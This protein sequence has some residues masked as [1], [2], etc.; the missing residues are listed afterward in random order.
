MKKTALLCCSLSLMAQSITIEPIVI[1]DEAIDPTTEVTT[2]ISQEENQER[3]NITMDEQLS[4][5]VSFSVVSDSKQNAAVSFRGLDYK[6]IRFVEDGIPLYVPIGGVDTNFMMQDGDIY[7]ND[8]SSFTST[9]IASM[10]GEVSIVNHL[11]SKEFESNVFA[12]LGTN[13]QLYRVKAGSMQENFYVQADA[14]YFSRKS[15]TL[16]NKFQATPV[17]G[18]GERVNSDKRQKNFSLK[19][20]LFVNDALELAAKVS[21]SKAVYGIAP[22]TQED[23]SAPTFFAFT[24]IDPQELGS[25]YLYADYE[26]ADYFITARLYYDDYKD[27]YEVYKTENY[28]EHLPLVTYDDAREGGTF[29]VGHRGNTHKTTFSL[30]AE[31][32]E[33]KR[34]GGGMNDITSRIA[35][36][37]AAFGDVYSITDTV[38]AELGASYAYMRAIK[39]AENSNINPV[40]DKKSL[41]GLLKL[42]YKSKTSQTYLSVAKKSRMPL[43]SEMV[44]AFP[45]ETSNPNLKP[46]RSMQYSL[47]HMQKLGSKSDVSFDLYYYDIKNLIVYENSSYVNRE[48]AINYGAEFKA[49]SSYFAKQNVSFSYAYTEAKDSENNPIQQIPKHKI[50]VEDRVKFSQNYKAFMAYSFIGSRFT[51]NSATYTSELEKL[52]SYHL[53]DAQLSYTPLKS[54]DFRAG[55]KNILDESYELEYGFPAE[56]RL[57]YISLE[58]KI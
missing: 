43:L 15:Y 4:A 17:Q 35:T 44:T 2:K 8:G 46:E 54:V 20:G 6:N 11:P 58:I 55:V 13:D 34:L 32:N 18:K 29:K 51:Q 37:N 19:T 27:I 50:R 56:G 12:S 42:K 9:G 41:D 21:Y 1:E 30:L 7:F 22:N 24:R 23:L 40:K 26:N 25:L 36:F 33:H 49:E 10:G 53:L 28:A 47:G 52:G 5:D 31:V 45:W 16:S 14:S 39:S 3:R 48:S 57:Y 38:S